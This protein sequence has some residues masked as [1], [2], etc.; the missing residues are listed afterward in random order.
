[1]SRNHQGNRRRTY[2]R[3]QHELHERTERSH[4]LLDLHDDHAAASVVAA[5]RPGLSPRTFAGAWLPVRG[6]H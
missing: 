1:M 2:G 3:R 5:W 4:E 6:I